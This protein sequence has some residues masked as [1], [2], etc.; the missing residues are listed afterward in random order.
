MTKWYEE[1]DQLHDVFVMKRLRLVR[2]IA[3]CIFPSRLEKEDREEMLQEELSRR[4]LPVLRIGQRPQQR[5]PS[6]VGLFLPGTGFT[7]A[8]SDPEL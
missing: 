6:G 7:G 3:D 8:G 4:S 1:T 2:N 5:I